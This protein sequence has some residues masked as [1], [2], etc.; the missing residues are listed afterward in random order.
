MDSEQILNQE[1]YELG[2]LVKGTD[3]VLIQNK[4]HVTE[5]TVNVVLTGKRKATRGKSLQIVK[6]AKKI[7]EINQ[8]KKDLI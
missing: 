3:R 6:M 1:A 4:L 7:A 5:S 2:K 8:A